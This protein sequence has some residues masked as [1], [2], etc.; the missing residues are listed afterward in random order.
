MDP[1]MGGQLKI[2][3]EIREAS[4]AAAQL[5]AHLSAATNMKTGTIDFTKLS[6]YSSSE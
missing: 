3:D 4:A 1:S 2:T 6:K 5:K